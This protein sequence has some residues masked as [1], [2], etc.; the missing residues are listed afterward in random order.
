MDFRLSRLKLFPCWTSSTFQ[1]SLL[2]S[3]VPQSIDSVDH[4]F[5][6]RKWRKI[7][8]QIIALEKLFSI[9][10]QY[11]WKL[12]SQIRGRVVTDIWPKYE[13]RRCPPPLSASCLFE[14]CLLWWWC[15]KGLQVI[16]V[17]SW[18][19]WSSKFFRLLNW[20]CWFG[21]SIR[22]SNLGIVQYEMWLLE[23][24]C[25]MLKKILD[26]TSKTLTETI[27]DETF[28][29]ETIPDETLPFENLPFEID[30]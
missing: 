30:C 14:R 18:T 25:N 24:I 4:L 11:H 8:D 23:F 1:V 29:D 2:V 27:P 26:L 13:W 19:S 20:N 3:L 15:I 6:V 16:Y 22:C 12:E 28:P 9:D 5:A 17:S 10:F 21:S 7:S